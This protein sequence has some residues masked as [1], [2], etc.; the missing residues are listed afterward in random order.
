MTDVVFSNT[1]PVD[2]NLKD[3]SQ[4]NIT[5]AA[6][7]GYSFQGVIGTNLSVSNQ[8]DPLAI[9]NGECSVT[10]TAGTATYVAIKR[11]SG[12]LGFYTNPQI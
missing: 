9:S 2:T 11:S 7:Y 10:C 8:T 6:A 5:D 4:A 12:A 1:S 3:I